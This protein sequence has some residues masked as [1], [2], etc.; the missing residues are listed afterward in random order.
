M[1]EN[2]F[3]EEKRLKLEKALYLSTVD[4]NSRKKQ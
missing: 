4:R 3:M 1:M 2:N